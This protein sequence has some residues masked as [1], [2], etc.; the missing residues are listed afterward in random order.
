MGIPLVDLK[1]QYARIAPEIED[2]L[3][4]VLS[5][6]GFVGGPQV[7][8]FEKE[9]AAYCEAPCALGV[10]SG[11]SALH[12]ALI[13]AGVGPG[14]EV[15]VPANTFIATSEVVRRCGAAI[16]FA[17][18]DPELST[19]DVAGCERAWTPRVKA[20]L[21]VHLY[22]HPADLDPILEFARDRG[23]RVIED[24]AQ[25]HGAR[26]H[27]RR[28]GGLATLGGFSF[29][30][31]KNLGAYGDAGAVTAGSAEEIDRLRRLSNHGRLDK[32]LHG[33]EGF[34]YRLD[35]M[36][37]A[38]LRVKLRHLDHWNEERRTAA[39][40]YEERLRGDERI[41]TPRSA[42]WA[43]PVY[44]LYVVRVPGRDRVLARMQEAGIGAG[45]HYPVPLHLQPAYAH[46]GHREGDFPVSERLASEILS[47]PLFPEITPAQ[48]DFVVETLRRAVD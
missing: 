22:G 24:A 46:L 42:P 44:H 9:F 11:T 13:A 31:G 26:Y 38:I 5:T 34:N 41:G 12:L 7:D 37:A 32:Y 29:Y 8:A 2:A 16:R 18:V 48:V 45:I 10:S 3:R 43:E 30:P 14:D 15:I 23:V 4:G 28:C 47:L 17:D 33:E 1:A 25:A 39:G 27:G 20:I 21:P 19:L 35:A 6:T 36:Q 40:W